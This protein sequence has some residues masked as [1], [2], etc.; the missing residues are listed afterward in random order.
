VTAVAPL[1]GQPLREYLESVTGFVV[2]EDRWRSIAPRLLQRVA[3]RNFQNTKAYV[4]H[5]QEDAFGRHE[6]EELLEVFTVRKT[7]F[8]RNPATYDVLDRE[9]MPRLFAARGKGGP[10]PSVWSAGCSTGEEPYSVAMVAR[11][12]APHVP[13]PCYILATDIVDA[14]L[15]RARRGVYASEVAREIPERW[16]HLL[17]S[18]EGR[19]EVTEAV[20]A[21]VEFYVHNL[22]RDPYPRPASGS[23][24]VIMCRNV[25]IYFGVETCRRVIQKMWD[26]L[27][28]D[29]ALFLGHS[30]VL[31]GLED[32]FDVVFAGETFYYR[33]KQLPLSFLVGT[34]PP[35][36]VGAKPALPAVGAPPPPPPSSGVMKALTP[37]SSGTN[38]ALTQTGVVRL[39]GAPPS[40]TEAETRAYP[41]PGAPR[42][43][44][45][46][47]SD[48]I[49]LPVKPPSGTQPAFIDKTPSRGV[50]IVYPFDL[51]AKAE[52]ALATGDQD[53]AARTLRLAI[54]RAPAWAPPRLLLGRLYADK[55]ETDRAVEELAIAARMAPLDSRVHLLLGM[56]R[57]RR[58]EREG[59]EDAYRHAVYLE[60]D[61][62]A[63]RYALAQIYRATNRVDRARRELRN[64]VRALT[65]KELREAARLTDGVSPTALVELCEREL[66]ELGDG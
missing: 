47:P 12:L 26:V 24:D 59:A 23:W 37:S 52:S 35:A 20:R 39:H 43:P 4:R 11:A 7:S 66:T 18:G 32:R 49:T 65:G 34:R 51:V 45:P 36:L 3:F 46:P 48:R 8:F 61:L 19:I 10:P 14:A 56:V 1:D 5:L 53:G 50:A 25:I 55:G 62:A 6:L 63:A 16:R 27:A 28:P 13:R 17:D 31:W 2:P 64:V 42:T 40:V 60:P 15:R 22:V 41:R 9:I 21:S 29:G 30:E 38:G 57:E 33:K 54:A 58:G 44:P